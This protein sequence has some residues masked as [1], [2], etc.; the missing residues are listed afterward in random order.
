MN[1][2]TQ[3]AFALFVASAAWGQQG[4]Q[5]PTQSI[6]A[7]GTAGLPVVSITAA[8]TGFT[9]E[10]VAN[11]S[12]RCAQA[13]QTGPTMTAGAALVCTTLSGDARMMVRHGTRLTRAGDTLLPT[14]RTV[15]QQG[16]TLG[17]LVEG[18]EQLEEDLLGQSAP[19]LRTLV[20]VDMPDL[21]CIVSTNGQSVLTR[22]GIQGFVFNEP[23]NV[24]YVETVHSR[25]TFATAGSV[26]AGT[27]G[28][29]GTS[30]TEFPVL[31]ESTRTLI[32]VRGFN[33]VRPSGF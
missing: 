18:L 25:T 26:T 24:L 29:C 2:L 30:A 16:T 23:L 31:H 12:E 5:W 13:Q 22:R 10:I 21:S 6:A 15:T 14:E 32:R 1:T 3:C 9:S 27:A 11:L 4:V 17:M 33:H 20:R 28:F 7:P 8:P 19:V